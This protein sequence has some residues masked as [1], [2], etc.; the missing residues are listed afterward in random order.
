MSIKRGVAVSILIMIVGII[1]MPSTK[2]LAYFATASAIA[3][4]GAGI[5]PLLLTSAIFSGVERNKSIPA[6]TSALSLSLIVGPIYLAL[7]SHLARVTLLISLLGLIPITG[8][9]LLAYMGASVDGPIRPIG[10]IS[11]N[12]ILGVLRNRGYLLGLILEVTFTVPF[13]A[14]TTYGAILADARGAG[15]IIAEFMVSVFFIASFVARVLMTYLGGK[16]SPL[17]VFVLTA[18]GL[19]TAALSATL[20]QLVVSFVLLGLAHGLAYPLSVEYVT[21]S[22]GQENLAWA[23]TVMSGVSAGVLFLTLPILGYLAQ[24]TGLS[25]VFLAPEPL[26]VALAL[27]FWFLKKQGEKGKWLKAAYQ[28]G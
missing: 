10:K 8:V 18:L 9:G 17:L 24:R 20:S 6:F 26:V 19:P 27:T 13:A 22:V 28:R 14:F 3:C 5:Q 25:A 4:I 12:N 11:V 21:E 2:S 16:A 23:N 15:G 7:L 1:M